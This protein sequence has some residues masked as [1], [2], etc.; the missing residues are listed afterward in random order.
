MRG[1]KLTITF[2]LVTVPCKKAPL[3]KSE[4]VSAKRICAEH[5]A[6]IRL[7]SVCS[8]H[9][10]VVDEP[11]S[12]YEDGAGGYTL[13]DREALAV[14]NDKVL[15]LK[16]FV[17]D[18]DPAFYE[19]SEILAADRG[20]ENSHSVLAA[21]LRERGGM[22]VGV[23]VVNKA[24]RQVGVRWSEALG[25]VTMHL[26]ALDRDVRWADAE[27]SAPGDVDAKQVA[28]AIQIL[29]SLDDVAELDAV[30]EY[31]ERVRAAVGAV[32]EKLVVDV[33]DLMEGLRASVA[34]V[35]DNKRKEKADV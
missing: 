26:L 18:F 21:A 22:A 27:A 14:E 17:D 3:V 6:P 34:A 10:H 7:Q 28:L 8:E 4:R 19:K 2:G 15:E 35:Q 31:D 5:M 32:E 9:D 25:C 23:M 30:D 20:G 12:A 13:V 16:A 29:E 33:P 1:T 11:V 24:R